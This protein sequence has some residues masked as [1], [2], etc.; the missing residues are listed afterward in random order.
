VHFDC[1][2]DILNFA[3]IRIMCSHVSVAE[4]VGRC[5]CQ[6]TYLPNINFCC[7]LFADIDVCVSC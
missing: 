6:F 3:G 4:C 1:I 5:G 7:N 2:N